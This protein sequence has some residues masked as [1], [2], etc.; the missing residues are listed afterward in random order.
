MLVKELKW[1]FGALLLSALLSFVFI[2]F[3]KMTD[4]VD[5]I[6]YAFSLKLYLSGLIIMLLNLYVGRF[7]VQSIRDHIA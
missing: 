4:R 6:K 3:L 7:L 5:G 1:F 2:Y